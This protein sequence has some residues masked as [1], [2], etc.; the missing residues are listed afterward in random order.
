MFTGHVLEYNVSVWDV[1]TASQCAYCMVSVVV[2]NFASE[3]VNRLH[4][5]ARVKITT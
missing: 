1:F 2:L 5:V 3:L 4:R